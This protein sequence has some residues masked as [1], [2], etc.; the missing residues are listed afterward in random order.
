MEVPNGSIEMR[1]ASFKYNAD[2][3]ADVLHDITLS[4][5]AGSTVGVLGGTGSGK[6]SL[7]Q[8]LPR[9]YDVTDGAVLIGGHDVREY[10]VAAL[11][12]SVGIAL[13][14]PVLFSG[15]VRENLLWGRSGRCDRG[16]AS[17]RRAMWLPSTTSLTESAALMPT[18]AREAITSAEANA[19][20]SASPGRS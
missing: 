9:L 1:H 19:S 7:V 3:S 17:T 16:A 2:A 14:R 10:D 4:F 18:S 11:R 8:L 6:S 15:T 5:P 12:E 20:D 13:Q